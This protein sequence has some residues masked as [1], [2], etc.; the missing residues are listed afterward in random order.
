M[1]SVGERGVERV[2]VRDERPVEGLVRVVLGVGGGITVAGRGDRRDGVERLVV[3]DDEFRCVRCAVAR[4]GQHDR[5]DLTD[6]MDLVHRQRIV[7]WVDH[8]LGD[9]P[10]AGQRCDPQPHL[11]ELGPGV[12]GVNA[13][14]VFGR[15]RVDRGDLGVRHRGADHTHPE[16]AR[17]LD[18]VDVF[19]FADEQLGILAALQGR[20]DCVHPAPPTE[21][22]AFTML[23]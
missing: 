8:V 11:L 16:L 6:V 10:G 21:R 19:A 9:R 7:R 3:D 2:R 22:T 5:H 18:V 15:G 12:D 17:H 13:F 23:W 1:V 4:V 20:S 14:G